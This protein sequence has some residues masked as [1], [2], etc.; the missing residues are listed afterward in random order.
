MKLTWYGHSCFLLENAAGGRLLTDPCDP[1]TGYALSDIVCDAV[2]MSHHHYDHDYLAAVTG[3][4]AALDTAKERTVAGFEVFG[5]DTFHDAE[6][7]AKRGGNVMFRIRADGVTLVHAGDLG[8]I[9]DAGTIAALGGVDVLL[10]PVG[11]VYTIDAKAAAETVSRIRPRVVIP[12]HYRTKALSFRLD[13]VTAFLG[14]T[15]GYAVR[16]ADTDTVDT[17]AL[18]IEAPE[19]VVMRYRGE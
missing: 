14:C 8:H 10:L 18:L 12:M 17:D 13:P 2:T 11:G 3:S 4:P 9:P 1:G 7:G 19:I 5:V 15:E 6:R 16:N